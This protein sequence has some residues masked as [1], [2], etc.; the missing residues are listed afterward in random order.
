MTDQDTGTI[1]VQI[2]DPAQMLEERRREREK[3][4]KTERLGLCGCL[5]QKFRNLFNATKGR[6]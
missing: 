4:H 2:V 3:K 5:C 1:K 6:A